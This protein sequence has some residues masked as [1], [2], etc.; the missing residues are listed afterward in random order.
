V[1]VRAAGPPDS[2][3]GMRL[4][5]ARMAPRIARLANSG[6]AKDTPM[7]LGWRARGLKATGLEGMPTE[8]M[9]LASA[10]PLQAQSEG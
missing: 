4:R 6:P 10:S 7:A 2:P 5:I 8:G 3:E 1:A 9:R